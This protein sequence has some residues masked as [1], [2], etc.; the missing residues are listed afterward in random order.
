MQSLP[1]KL[2]GTISIKIENSPEEEDLFCGKYYLMP[3]HNDE[4]SQIY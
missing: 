2:T 1:G 3:F 4:T